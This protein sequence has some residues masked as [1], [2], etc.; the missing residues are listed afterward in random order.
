MAGIPTQYATAEGSLYELVA[1][2]NKDVFFYEDT[3]KSTYIFDS[4]YQP[5]APSTFEIRR[6]PPHT[7]CEFG[8]TVNFEFD[9]VG[10]LMTNPTLVINLPTW[11]P[12][13]VASTNLTSIVTDTSTSKVSYGYTNGIGF[14]LFELIQF[15]QDNIL[16]QEFSGDALWATTKAQGTYTQSFV[17]TELTGQHDGSPLSIGRNATPPQLRLSLPL[18]GCQTKND[19][20]FPQRSTQSHTYRLR[21]KIRKL[22]DLIEASD[23]RIKP[24]PWGRTDFQ[25]KQVS[26]ESTPTPFTT[27]LRTQI[28]PL[29]IQLE[30]QQVYV[31]REYQDILQN[32]PQSLMFVRQ[33][34]NIFTQNQLDYAGVV[35]GGTSLVKRLLDGRHPSG[36]VVWF[37]RSIRDINANQ[38]W[39]VNTGIAGQQSYFNSVNLQIAGKDR[40]LPRNSFVWRD[41]ANFSKEENDT[42]SEIN[43]M[44]WTLGAIAPERFPGASSQ[45]TGAVNFTTAD[46]PIFYIDLSLPPSDPYT[47][48][49]NTELRV[50]VEG[51]ARFDTDGTG[52]AELFSGN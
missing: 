16:L 15:Y 20:G 27:L 4:S 1:R 2:G 18:I 17:V 50:I 31:P 30:T 9:L 12:P 14:F 28:L 11:L 48:A 42:G 46:K 26:S 39:K 21:C 24:I 10:D 3:A 45:E 7:A 22:E 40:E 32:K 13:Q 5:Q 49:P 25:Q 35:G 8:R 41:I 38:L 29:D 43:T 37:M 52:R 6:V 36:R 44:N 19:P 23:G 47:G 34:E 51:W 33:W